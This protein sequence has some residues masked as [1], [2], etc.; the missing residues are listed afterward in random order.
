MNNVYILGGSQTDFERNWT[1]EGK[2]YKAL[3]REVFEDTLNDC[4]LKK[5]DIIK[6]NNEDR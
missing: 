6:L 5:E 1:K 3:I 2:N 4:N